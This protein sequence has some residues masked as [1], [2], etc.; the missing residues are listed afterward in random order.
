MGASAREMERL[1]EETRARMDDNRRRLWGLA[2]SM[3]RRN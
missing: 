2:Q 1:I 3:A